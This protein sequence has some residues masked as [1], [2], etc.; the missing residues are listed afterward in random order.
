MI[1]EKVRQSCAKSFQALEQTSKG[2]RDS[3]RRC[4]KTLVVTPLKRARGLSACER[5]TADGE[6]IDGALPVNLKLPKEI[7]VEEL[8]L[9]AGLIKLVITDTSYRSEEEHCNFSFLRIL[10][11]VPWEDVE[12][13]GTSCGQ[14]CRT[15]CRTTWEDEYPKK[16]VSACATGLKR[17][18]I[19]GF[20]F[21]FERT[22]FSFLER[23]PKLEALTLEGLSMARHDL[24]YDFVVKHEH[25]ASLNIAGLYCPYLGVGVFL[26]PEYQPDVDFPFAL[27]S[28]NLPSLR[29]LSA[30]VYDAGSRMSSRRMCPSPLL[31][32]IPGFT[33]PNTLRVLELYWRHFSYVDFRPASLYEMLEK[34][35]P[36]LQELHVRMDTPSSKNAKERTLKWVS[37]QEKPLEGCP[38]L[39]ELTFEMS[40]NGGK[41][42]CVK[43]LRRICRL[44]NPGFV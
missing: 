4:T 23:F 13:E 1:T 16:I 9:R 35:C 32:N 17:L 37:E 40:E 7:L 21:R 28:A 34:D 43:T 8:S 6:L 19:T 33:F 18:V 30:T 2:L 44:R 41:W 24:D 12:I 20:H 27:V 38:E 26:T 31:V 36:Q 3:A 39:R 10:T 22:V 29:H 14:R 11:E 5:G 25:L 15:S 42:E